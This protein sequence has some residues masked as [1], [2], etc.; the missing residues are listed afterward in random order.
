MAPPIA[1]CGD[2][3]FFDNVN[4]EYGYCRRWV[5]DVVDHGDRVFVGGVAGVR[6]VWPIVEDDEWCG[7]Y[8]KHPRLNLPGPPQP[9]K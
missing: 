1:R 3:W 4:D 7:E 6:G 5:P 8:R 9:S 2:C